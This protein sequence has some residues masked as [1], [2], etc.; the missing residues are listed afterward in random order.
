MSAVN[1][2]TVK[3]INVNDELI[4]NLMKTLYYDL[5]FFSAAGQRED[6]FSPRIYLKAPP[7]SFPNT[8]NHITWVRKISLYN[9]FQYCRIAIY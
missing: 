4:R 3:L 9:T 8:R 6:N 7:K 1:N 5:F 2:E